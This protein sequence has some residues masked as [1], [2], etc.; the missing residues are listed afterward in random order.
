MLNRE[1]ILQVLQ[2]QK[3]YFLSELSV[4]SIGLFGSYARNNSRN[5]SDIDILVDMP[6]D[7]DKMCQLWKILEQELQA[8]I[9]LVRVGS[10]LRKSF[11]ADIRKEIIY[12]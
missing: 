9:D 6:P 11:L 12:A 7:Y 3:P 1:I 8:K 4:K 2:K 10:H 5:G